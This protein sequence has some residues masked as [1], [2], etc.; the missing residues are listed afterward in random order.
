M[1]ATSLSVTSP[2]ALSLE[3]LQRN[4]SLQE[5]SVAG[6][7]DSPRQTLIER[8]TKQTGIVSSHLEP[9]QQIAAT[10]NSIIGI[11]PV[12]SVATGLIEAGHPTKDFHIKGKSANWGPQAGLICTDQAFS[13]LESAPEKV[14]KANA[15]ILECVE[16]RHAVPIPLKLSS[17]RLNELVN[18]GHITELAATGEEGTLK[19]SAQGPSGQRYT[20]Q[21]RSVSPDAD[22]YLITHQGKPLE[23]LA[24]QA[25]GKPL[26]ADYDL[27]MV[28][29]HLS[30]YGAQDKLPVPDV[31]HSVFKERINAYKQV[32]E[33]LRADFA[34]AANFYKKEDA[35]LGNATPRI[36]EMI[37]IINQT[38]V[39][40]AERVVHH[41]AD[42]GSPAT[43]VAAN[44]P[45]TFFL[46]SKLGRFDE[47]S[48]IH[49][50]REMA[51]LIKTAK[52]SGFHVPL[53][54]LW[55]NE[56]VNI[57]RSDFTQAKH[58]LAESRYA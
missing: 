52:D 45:A 37:G 48:I 47:I 2:S 26:T 15:Q 13:K 17:H 51:E 43:E 22:T 53:N 24:K 9:L 36:R 5:H 7:S 49:D 50:S 31:A 57:R 38:L 29:P 55:E 6:E 35:D 41:N 28:A 16:R 39:G 46:P 14:A 58:R 3:A 27:H 1:I 33:E 32:P 34:S 30:D 23:V 19:L 8:V 4:Q 18:L 10:T 54:P 44:Y 12:E 21:A 25:E 42:S 20:F 40:D 56:L 11:R